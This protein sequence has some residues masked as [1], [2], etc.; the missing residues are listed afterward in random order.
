MTI[1]LHGVRM[2]ML[3]LKMLISDKTENLCCLDCLTVCSARS[4]ATYLSMCVCVNSSTL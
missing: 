3:M 1:T 2:L 4:R